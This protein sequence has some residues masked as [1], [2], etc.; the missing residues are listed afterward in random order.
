MKSFFSFNFHVLLEQFKAFKC[1]GRLLFV[2]AFIL[3]LSLKK[4]VRLFIRLKHVVMIIFNLLT[5]KKCRL[6]FH[7][8]ILKEYMWNI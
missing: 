8:F 3:I 7:S 5:D 6:S 4:S 1:Y 2:G